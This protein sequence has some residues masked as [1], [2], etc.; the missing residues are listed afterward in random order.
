LISTHTNP[1]NMETPAI[2][3]KLRA[4]IKLRHLV[5]AIHTDWGQLA[6][7]GVTVAGCAVPRR[8]M[9]RMVHC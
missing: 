2:N 5:E 3:S 7:V 9:F 4:A 8:W 6:T 1:M